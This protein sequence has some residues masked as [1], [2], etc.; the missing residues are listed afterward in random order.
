MPTTVPGIEARCMA[1]GIALSRAASLLCAALDALHP[2]RR[3]AQ[4]VAMTATARSRRNVL[5]I[6]PPSPSLSPFALQS[7]DA[8][9]VTAESER[10]WRGCKL[11]LLR[12]PTYRPSGRIIP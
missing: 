2:A 12:A 11:L 8:L 7:L 1:A 5:F 10:N 9:V 6:S 3:P 4:N